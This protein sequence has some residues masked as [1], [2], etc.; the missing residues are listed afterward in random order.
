MPEPA[1][2]S[3][4]FQVPAPVSTTTLVRGRSRVSD[5]ASMARW[6]RRRLIHRIEQ[7]TGRSLLCYVGHGPRISRDDALGFHAL[8]DALPPGTPLDLLLHSPGGDVNAAEKLVLMLRAKVEGAA[9][10]TDDGALRIIV[11]DWAKSAATLMSLGADRIVMSDTSE[12]GP[13]DPQFT[14]ARGDRQETYSAWD[15]LRALRI[16]EE[17]CR[18]NPENA[19]FERAFRW[20]DPL[21]TAQARK[22]IE[23]VRQVARRL[24]KQCG[25]NYTPGREPPRGRIDDGPPPVSFARADD[26]F[27]GGTR[28]RTETPAVH[29]T[30]DP[31]LAHVLGPLQG[32]AEG[33]RRRP[34]GPSSRARCPES[35]R[36]HGNPRGADQANWL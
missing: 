31:T 11:P 4:D 24:L 35:S 26:R 2:T 30:H 3:A 16:A 10:P 32:A 18:A 9:A 5:I 7:E 36:S 20:F 28:H 13:I 29:G 8:L 23:R 17:R 15:Y 34:E 21:H 1:S 19:V 25:S 27:P 14:V 12:L 22:D 6:R 33:L